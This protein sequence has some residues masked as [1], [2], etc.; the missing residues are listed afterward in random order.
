MAVPT[1]PVPWLGV[2]EVNV[3]PAGNVS[4][5]VTA[6]ALAG[7]LFVTV[8]E[9]VRVPLTDTG[10]GESVFVIDRSAWFAGAFTVVVPGALLFA[11]FGSVSFAVTLAV[12]LNVPAAV[13]V[14]TI[15]T[16]ALA[17]LINVPRVHETVVVPVQLP[18][19]V[20]DETNVAPAGNGSVIT[21]LVAELGPLLVTV[22]V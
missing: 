18:C 3:T 10:S 4:V 13:G 7:P 9:Y 14:T 11:V 1:Q 12:L 6:A 21:T 8:I 17:P 16:V 22:I 15:V 2:A 5:T 20:D 19:V